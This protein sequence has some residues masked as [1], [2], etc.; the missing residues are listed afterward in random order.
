[1]VREKLNQ[2]SSS[3]SSFSKIF[4]VRNMEA[5]NQLQ[6]WVNQTL[7]ELKKWL[8]EPLKCNVFNDKLIIETV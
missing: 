8:Q 5:Q 3:F 1:M 6:V 4:Q 7:G 2:Q